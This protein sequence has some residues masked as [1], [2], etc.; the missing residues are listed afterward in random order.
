MWLANLGVVE[1][2][3]AEAI[4]GCGRVRCVEFILELARRFDEL[5]AASMRLE[6]RV[7][8]LEEQARVDRVR[9][10]RRRLRIRRRRV[11][12]VVRRPGRRRRSCW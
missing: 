2:V 11:S 10:R 6:G 12:S 4:Y 1:R 5:S 7:R 8:R 9:V 3:E